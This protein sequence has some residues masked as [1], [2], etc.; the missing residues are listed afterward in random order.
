M[1]SDHM[2]FQR[3]IIQSAPVKVIDMLRLPVHMFGITAEQIRFHI[4]VFL[5]ARPFHKQPNH[6]RI[7]PQCGWRAHISERTCAVITLVFA[8]YRHKQ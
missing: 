3:S 4:P 2:V 5:A 7:Q 1:R 6:G 8:D